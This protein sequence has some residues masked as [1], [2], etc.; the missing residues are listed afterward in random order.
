MHAISLR[1]TISKYARHYITRSD[2]YH[3]LTPQ[4]EKRDCSHCSNVSATQSRAGIESL[5]DAIQ[6]V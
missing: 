4:L 1:H 3:E 5:H 2:A 6:T